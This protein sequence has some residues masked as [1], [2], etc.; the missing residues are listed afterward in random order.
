METLLRHD[1]KHVT[2]CI[3]SKRSSHTH[4][5]F[6][7]LNLLALAYS[8][9]LY[10][11]R[12]DSEHP[13]SRC[14]IL[15]RSRRAVSGTGK[16]ELQLG[17]CDPPSHASWFCSRPALALVRKMLS[18]LLVSLLAGQASAVRLLFQNDLSASTDVTSALL[19]EAAS[20]GT[21]AS[22]ACSAYNE[23]LLPA[24][25]SD[26]QD[27]LSYLVF[28]GDL[29][30]SSRLYIGSSSNASSTP[31]LRFARRQS[32]QCQAY[33]IGSAAGIAIDCGTELVC[34]LHASY[35]PVADDHTCFGI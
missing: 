17:L 3:Q 35:W 22:S 27:Q 11:C 26:I 34:I 23:Q 12:S 21:Q 30:N 25:N 33:D 10:T 20:S 15:C 5:S 1:S 14:T 7:Q 4:L 32:Q 2:Q 19:L 24:V 29:T 18:V 8:D 9:T 6:P 31:A 28:R 16:A 13:F